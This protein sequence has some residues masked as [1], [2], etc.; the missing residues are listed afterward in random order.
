LSFAIAAALW[1]V[2]VIDGDL[3]LAKKFGK[4]IIPGDMFLYLL[5]T[6]S[7]PLLLAFFYLLTDL[8]GWPLLW[9]RPSQ[10]RAQPSVR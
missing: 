10:T 6:S 4:L 7:V 2:G 8:L 3:Y 1:I 5:R 9:P